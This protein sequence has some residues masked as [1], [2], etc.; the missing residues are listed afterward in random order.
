MN[1]KIE[2][3][4]NNTNETGTYSVWYKDENGVMHRRI[5]SENYVN[6]LLDMRQKERFFMGEYK[7]KVHSEY[8]FTKIVLNGEKVQGIGN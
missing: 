7:F 3:H 6:S 4:D 1:T 5:L 8:D 2:I